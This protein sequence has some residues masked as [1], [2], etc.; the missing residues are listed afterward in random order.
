MAA[1]PWMEVD[2]GG[3]MLLDILFYICIFQ[4]DGPGRLSAKV[5]FSIGL[6]HSRAYAAC[7]FGV[8]SHIAIVCNTLI[9]ISSLSLFLSVSRIFIRAMVNI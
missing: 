2:G 6:V 5:S 7:I 3:W 1:Q 8:H 4:T 9:R